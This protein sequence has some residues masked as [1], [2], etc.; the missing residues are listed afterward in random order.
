M[1][2]VDK[3]CFSPIFT[4]SETWKFCFVLQETAALTQEMV[5]TVSAVHGSEAV[6]CA[7]LQIV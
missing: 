2:P 7:F 1:S 4:T 6:S 5:E 3:L